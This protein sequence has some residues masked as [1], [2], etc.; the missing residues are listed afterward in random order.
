MLENFLSQSRKRF[1]CS[2]SVILKLGLLYLRT[3]SNPRRA[4]GDFELLIILN[5]CPSHAVLTFQVIKV[6]YLL[7]QLLLYW[8]SSD[9]HCIVFYLYLFIY[10]YYFKTGFLDVALVVLELMLQS[11]LAANSQSSTCLCLPGAGVK[12]VSQHHLA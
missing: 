4:M 6:L 12:G 7:N 5:K 1:N 2:D 11:K 9:S 3:G 8:E 10:L